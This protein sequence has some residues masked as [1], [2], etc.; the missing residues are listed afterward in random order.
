VIPGSIA[1]SRGCGEEMERRHEDE[2]RRY[3]GP[4]TLSIE[5]WFCALLKSMTLICW[6]PHARSPWSASPHVDRASPSL[7]QGKGPSAGQ[8]G[9]SVGPLSSEGSGSWAWASRHGRREGAARP[10]DGFEAKPVDLDFSVPNTVTCGE[11][12]KVR[13]RHCGTSNEVSAGSCGAS[14]AAL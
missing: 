2:A 7:D 14:G 1:L 3:G 9:P 10:D 5:N 11:P 6:C 8:H 4:L 13:C 12:I